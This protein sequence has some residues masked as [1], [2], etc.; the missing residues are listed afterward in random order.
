MDGVT[1]A[2]RSHYF[3]N[4]LGWPPLSMFQ[5]RALLERSPIAFLSYLALLV[6]SLLPLSLSPADTIAYVG[7]SLDTV[8]FMAWNA[9]QLFHDPLQL[10]D[11]NLL[12]PH[13]GASLFD[14]HRLLPSI[15]AAPLIW[16]TG[17]P[18]LAAN[19]VTGFA[20]VF[21]AMSGRY[22]AR[23]LGLGP[24]PAWVA[25]ALYGFHTYQIN[26]APRVN[27]V[28]HGFW[29]LAIAELLAYLRGGERLHA[30][31]LGGLMLL[32]GLAD[33]Y[34][35]VYAVLIL[36]LVTLASAVI[37]F[38]LTLRRVPGLLPPA[39]VAGLLFLP[40]VIPYSRAASAYDYV[41]ETPV[42]ID[43]Q[44]YVSTSPG[45][46]MYGPMGAKVTLQQRGPHFVGFAALG[47]ALLAV[48][49]T[50]KRRDE[51]N[52]SGLV[53]FRLW[54]PMAAGMVVVFVWLSLGRDVVA[55]GQALG[56]GPYRL[57]HALPAFE[58]M[59][60][61][62]RLGLVAMLFVALL[63]ARGVA[64]LQQRSRLL[65]TVAAVLV[66]L[67][68]LS[69]MPVN[70]RV[71]VGDQVPKVY[72]WL[73]TQEVKALA[74][75]PIHGEGLIRKESLEEYFS[76]YHWK[77]II[78]GYVSYPPLLTKIL[79]RAASEFPSEMSLQVFD[80]V[81]VDTVVVHRDRPGAEAMDAGIADVVARGRLS[82]LAR[83]LGESLREG[84]N[85]GQDVYRIRPASPWAAAPLP[86]GNPIPNRSWYYRAKE[87]DA[88]LAAD[89]DPDTAWSVPRPLHG[90]EFWE[91][92][93]GGA[94]LELDS[95]VLPLGRNSAFPTRFR[96]AGRNPDGS[97]TELARFDDAHTLQVVDQ[98]LIHP[99]R[100][101]LGF[102]LGGRAAMGVSL[103]VSQGAT[104]YDGW[105][106]E[107]VEI[108]TRRQRLTSPPRK[109][110][111]ASAK[112]PGRS[113]RR[114]GRR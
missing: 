9:H 8:Y 34:N 85:R 63:A 47:L 75:V 71:P 13:Q 96:V 20:L 33:N 60:I 59:R 16:A 110:P 81:G 92:T 11:A 108:L 3:T 83:F 55:F 22:L 30:W 5:T 104:S 84:V 1:F 54:V 65:A 26:E 29:P 15:L 25:G 113:G 93:F 61:P 67:E 89:G 21:A 17:N 77:P 6:A 103:L 79:R 102:D 52:P 90:D 37:D 101:R 62:E 50:I 68:H 51:G 7:D 18:V 40:I 10:F 35:V 72:R 70:E 27:V 14:T 57:L 95:L 82:L 112:S 97:W 98:L 106:L 107:E 99:G 111:R 105:R 43:L 53:P 56:P 69:V 74:E 45:N 48:G 39:L 109:R 87:G 100:A 42:G 36:V 76:T 64:L 24:L 23:V 46:I 91:V 58:F 31:R 44:H 94:S 38:R 32:Q 80:R 2:H 12:Y 66:P 4:L 41:R 88:A 28:F 78:H 114:R 73:A 49:S 86:S 19:L